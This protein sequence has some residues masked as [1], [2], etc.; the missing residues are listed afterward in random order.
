MFPIYPDHAISLSDTSDFESLTE[1]KN[2][3]NQLSQIWKSTLMGDWDALNDQINTAC[4]EDFEQFPFEGE[5]AGKGILWFVASSGEWDLFNK[6]LYFHPNAVL[7]ANDPTMIY[8]VLEEAAIEGQWEQPFFKDVLTI[9]LLKLVGPEKTKIDLFFSLLYEA[10]FQEKWKIVKQLIQSN[11]WVKLIPENKKEDIE[12]QFLYSILCGKWSIARNILELNPV[13]NLDM[14]T[15]LK[16]QSIIDIIIKKTTGFIL[17]ANQRVIISFCLLLGYDA[18]SWTIIKQQILS[19]IDLIISSEIWQDYLKIEDSIDLPNFKKAR[20]IFDKALNHSNEV[21]FLYFPELKF[22][23]KGVLFKKILARTNSK[24]AIEKNLLGKNIFHLASNTL[25]SQMLEN[26]FN[27]LTNEEIEFALNEKDDNNQCAIDFIVKLDKLRFKQTII[28]NLTNKNLIHSIDKI[29][30][31]CPIFFPEFEVQKKENSLY[32]LA[33]S[34]EFLKEKLEILKEYS[35]KNNIPIFN[36]KIKQVNM[37][38]NI[39]KGYTHFMRIDPFFS[40]NVI[41][42]YGSQTSY[43]NRNCHGAALLAS[44]VHDQLEHFNS[45]F[46][47]DKTSDKINNISLKQIST[48][49]LIFLKKGLPG[50]KYEKNEDGLHSFVYLAP[51][52]CLSMNG[53]RQTLEFYST[54][55]ILKNYEYPEDSLD[56]EVVNEK[57]K[58]VRKSIFVLRKI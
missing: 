8:E 58:T 14:K 4:R 19:I 55:D 38:V 42:A 1:S 46:E 53:K 52:F 49:D 24:L 47:Y 7:D 48:N 23:P 34:P 2:S 51:D 40:K 57:L 33:K 12:F 35:E 36:S 16:K 6:I 17:T 30:S 54:K 50:T 27:K 11:Q 56:F 21:F 28:K 15:D 20:N 10:V 32:L 26:L 44:G 39:A 31:L 5:H 37:P 43:E 9:P 25:N 45:P 18:P 22:I 41:N 3:F 29:C 13:V